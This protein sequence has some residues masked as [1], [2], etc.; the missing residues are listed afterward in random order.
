M[1][2]QRN[3]FALPE[4]LLPV[5]EAVE[6]KI[7]VSYTLIG[8]FDAP[9]LTPVRAGQALPSLHSPASGSSVNCATYLVL[10]ADV[11]V[12]VRQVQMKTGHT[13]FAV[14][15]L[16][17]PSSITLTHGGFDNFMTLISGRVATASDAAQAKR[18]QS[19]F[20][21]A[22]GKRFKRVNTYWVGAKAMQHFQ[23]G[24]RLTSNASSPPEYDLALP[25]FQ[26]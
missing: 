7:T 22:I 17:N 9:D 2:Q 6:S 26:L 16:L 15:Q 8:M 24:G 5:F 25:R 11:A 21:K 20:S 13:R 10:P 23:R 1:K 4:D 3:F 12:E 19:A 14:D 18:L